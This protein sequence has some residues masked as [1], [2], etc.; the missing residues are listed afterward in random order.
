M[1]RRPRTCA[2]RAPSGPWC[3]TGS[4][5]TWPNVRALCRRSSLVRVHVCCLLTPVW[6]RPRSGEGGRK[7]PVSSGPLTPALPTGP[8]RTDVPG[9][10]P[11][12]DLP[13]DTRHSQTL[14]PELGVPSHGAPAR[15]AGSRQTGLQEGRGVGAGA[16]GH[17][18]LCQLRA[19]LSRGACPAVGGGRAPEVA[20]GWGDRGPAEATGSLS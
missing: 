1:P 16:Q 6:A 9:S 19:G 20:A 14:Q 3:W 5:V 7:R 10:R 8:T 2:R 18:R 11:Q 15:L 13:L 17:P 12:E 4:P